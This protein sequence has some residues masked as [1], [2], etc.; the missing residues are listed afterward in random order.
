M[1]RYKQRCAICK[2]DWALVTSVRQKFPVCKTC[3]MKQVVR[4]IED[5]AFKKFFDLPLKMYEE[6]S[7]LRS[8]RYQFG[9]WGSITENQEKAFKK[10]VKEIK[11]KLKPKKKTVKKKKPSSKK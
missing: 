2:N 7:F 10:A 3:E 6:N 11:K 8:V 1:V 4:P 9:R 5:K